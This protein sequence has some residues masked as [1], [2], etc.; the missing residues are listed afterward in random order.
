MRNIVLIGMPASGKSTIGVLLAKALGRDF[1]DT[2]LLIQAREGALLQDIIM[3]KGIDEF[4]RI[5]EEVITGLDCTNT[6]I[7]TGGSVVYSHE[8]MEY[9]GQKGI[10]VYLEVDYEEINRRLTNITSRGIVFEEG[11]NLIDLYNERLP[12]YQKYADL[13]IDCRD[14]DVETL[15]SLIKDKIQN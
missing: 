12:L 5:E 7:A 11:Q 15:V 9:L 8:A 3:D 10:I 1:I 13:T 4:I 2:D 14:K 6:V